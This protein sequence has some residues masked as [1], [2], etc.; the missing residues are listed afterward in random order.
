MQAHR[1]DRQHRESA[2]VDQERIFVGAVAAAAILH[3]AQAAGGDLVGNTMIEQDD[4]IGD[5]FL[6]PVSGQRFS[7]RSPVMTAVTP[8]F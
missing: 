7:P 6:E 3:D 4:A 1:R 2:L 5:V 8:T